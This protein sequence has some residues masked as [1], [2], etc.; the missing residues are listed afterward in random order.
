MKSI[1]QEVNELKQIVNNV[2]LLDLES[3]NR[4]REVV[5]ARKV[6]S[7]ILR[8]IGYKYDVIGRSIN[9][10]HS[11]IVH[12]VSDIESIMPYDRDIKDKYIA[13]EIAFG[14][15]KNYQLNDL[16]NDFITHIEHF[17]RKNGKSEIV[18]K[19]RDTITPLFDK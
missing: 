16:L 19:I 18:S 4:K 14:R 1:Q 7:K 2:F 12:Y 6:Y 8:N 5:D 9:K 11:T 17:E 15:K 13:C 10:D 3:K